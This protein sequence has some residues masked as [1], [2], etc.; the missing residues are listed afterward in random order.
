MSQVEKS[1]GLNLSRVVFLGRTWEEYLLIFN[2]SKG[3]LLGR[4]VLDCPS[5]ACS[6]TAHANQHGADGTAT[7]IAYYFEVDDL[8]RKGSQDIDYVM[9]S[10]GQAKN[11]YNWNYFKNVDELKNARIRALTD[12]NI[13]MRKFGVGCYVPAILPQLPFADSQFDLTLSAH[14]LFTYADR[15]NFDFNIQ[16]IKELIRVTRDEIRFFPTVDMTGKRCEYMGTLID[17]VRDRGW[18]AEEIQVHYEFKRM[19]ILCSS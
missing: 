14:F 16:T 19:P 5:G 17:W 13:D 2:L 10:L 12:C 7:D 6:F 3:D 18:V 8:E 4:K 15:L 1:E 9:Q 11:Y